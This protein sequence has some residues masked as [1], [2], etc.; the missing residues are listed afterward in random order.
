VTVWFAS[1]LHLDPTTPEIAGRFRRFLSGPVRGAH[2]LFL[3][4]DLFEA[5]IGDDDPEPAHR[6]VIDSIAAVAAAGTNTFV[7]RGN[8]DF[9]IGERFCAG[10]GTTL[11]DDPSI[12]TIGGERVLLTHGDGLCVDDRPYQRL[13]ALVRDPVIR[14]DFARLPI[15][16]R[17]RLATQARAGSREHLANTASYITDVNQAA[18][19]TVLEDA[20][21]ALMIHGHTHRPGVHRFRSGGLD[22]VRVVLGAWHDEA[23]VV[24]WDDAGWQL[25][26]CPA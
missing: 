25:L 2:A 4:G 19:E 20:G 24:R 1:D 9:M 21:L 15:N 11:L 8:R 16:A 23:N 14:D 18:V 17:R 7:M 3:L 26:P 5:W 12:L 6:D 22:R 13:R 10:S